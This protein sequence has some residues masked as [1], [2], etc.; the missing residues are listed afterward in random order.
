MVPVGSKNAELI[1]WPML[2]AGRGAKKCSA[3][4]VSA[5]WAEQNTETRKR[6]WWGA[7][8]ILFLI[9]PILFSPDT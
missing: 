5:V 1:F 9:L 3:F 7:A 2:L 6:R 8:M 4:F